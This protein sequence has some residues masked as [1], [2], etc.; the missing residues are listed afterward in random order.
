MPKVGKKHFS[1]TAKGMAMAK[2]EAKKTGKKVITGGVIGTSPYK[3]S[4]TRRK[5]AEDVL[6]SL[7]EAKSK[8]GRTTA[9]KL[10]GKPKGTKTVVTGRLLG[11]KF[12]DLFNDEYVGRYGQEYI[13]EKKKVPAYTKKQK[14]MARSIQN[15]M[16]SDRTRTYGRAKPYLKKKK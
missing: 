7:K 15:Q 5:T 11:S 13:E 3:K 10:T 2:A 12:K 4:T 8:A 14:A 16:I 6:K 1:Y 9:L